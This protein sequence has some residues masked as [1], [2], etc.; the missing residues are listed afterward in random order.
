MYMYIE[1]LKTA[2]IR[3]VLTFCFDAILQFRFHRDKMFDYKAIKID[4]SN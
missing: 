2:L 4:S 1:I 3:D